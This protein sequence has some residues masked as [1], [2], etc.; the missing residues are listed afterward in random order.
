M[1]ISRVF[2]EYL[3]SEGGVE[4]EWRSGGAGRLREVEKLKS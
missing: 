2:H 3:M 1:S 4:E